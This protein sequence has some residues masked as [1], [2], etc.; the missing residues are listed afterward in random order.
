M[1]VLPSLLIRSAR[2][3]RV[4]GYCNDDLA[5][6]VVFDSMCFTH[7]KQAI[8]IL[9][10][11]GQSIAS[12]TLW[13]QFM[14]MFNAVQYLVDSHQGVTWTFLE[15]ILSDARV[16]DR[17]T[18]VISPRWVKT[19]ISGWDTSRPK[20]LML[21]Q[22]LRQNFFEGSIELRTFKA[23]F[24][25]YRNRWERRMHGAVTTGLPESSAV[26]DRLP[27]YCPSDYQ[28][29]ELRWPLGATTSDG[30]VPRAGD[31]G[32]FEDGD[33]SL[34]GMAGRGGSTLKVL[35]NLAKTCLGGVN[36]QMTQYKSLFGTRHARIE[37]VTATLFRV[38][39]R[40]PD[41]VLESEPGLAFQTL[42]VEWQASI[43][44]DIDLQALRGQVQES[45]SYRYLSGTT[46]CLIIDDSAAT[47]LQGLISFGTIGNFIYRLVDPVYLFVEFDELGLLLSA[48]WSFS[49]DPSSEKGFMEADKFIC[50][51]L[52]IYHPPSWSRLTYRSLGKVA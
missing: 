39:I 29:T 18:V 28:G 23:L 6:F 21:L 8:F 16:D 47:G 40:P 22:K 15:A 27:Q 17:G 4:V 48:R 45:P 34:P 50:P 5:N 26:L 12:Q 35:G 10:K 20:F 9:Q 49:T 37:R 41:N 42:D 46:L 44:G 7:F 32:H 14:E 3:P 30:S 25:P 2:F 13:R 11:T 24:Y 51:H 1:I 31:I 33:K 43:A 52:T 36:L 19:D 38:T